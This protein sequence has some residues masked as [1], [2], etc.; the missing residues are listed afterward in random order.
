ML[1]HLPGSI[2]RPPP[3]DLQPRHAR[4]QDNMQILV[5]CFIKEVRKT[6]RKTV[7]FVQSKVVDNVDNASYP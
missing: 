7:L 5:Q 6:V 2:A 4:G 1:D 3:L